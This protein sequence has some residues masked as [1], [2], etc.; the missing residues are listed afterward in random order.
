MKIFARIAAVLAFLF[1]FVGGL[2]ILVQSDFKSDKDVF[3]IG[4][5]FCFIGIAF[6]VGPILWLLSGKLSG[7]EQ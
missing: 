1:C 3:P 2:G 5:A 4:I 6:F 7:R